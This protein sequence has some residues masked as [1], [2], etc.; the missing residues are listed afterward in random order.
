MTTLPGLRLPGYV[1]GIDVSAVQ[2]IA[3]PQAVYD[4]GFR[5]AFVKLSEGANYCDPRAQSHLAAL[6]SAG[7]H[8]GG[9]GFARVAGEPR[10]QARATVDRCAGA[11][12]LVRPVL[13][14]ETA[15]ADWSS[16]ALF[17]WAVDWLAEASRAGCAP[18]LYSYTSFLSG[19][20]TVADR[21][22]LLAAAPLWLAQYRSITSA[23][24]PASEADMPKGYD[25]QLWQYSG[26]GGHPVPGIPGATDRNLF[27]GD[28]SA[29]RAWFGLPPDGTTLDMGGP[30]HGS[31]V[32]DAA[33]GRGE[34]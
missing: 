3:D 34:D 18:V 6:R 27:R 21:R 19:R 14:L 8:V 24:A 11:E 31:H 7:L 16:G 10:A 23:W 13:D 12:H 9:Y 5:F 32:V 2:R 15:P 20:L 33:L 29:L 4:A 30:V 26:D 1:D 22:T 17:A 28:E 25:W